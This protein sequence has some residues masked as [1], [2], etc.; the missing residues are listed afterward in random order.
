MHMI[1]KIRRDG[2]RLVPGYAVC[3]LRGSSSEH[4][5]SLIV[6]RLLLVVFVFIGARILSISST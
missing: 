3:L 6:T 4:S 5:E 1:S 2:K